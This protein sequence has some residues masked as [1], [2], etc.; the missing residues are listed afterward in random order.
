MEE[1]KMQE[2]PVKN[3]AGEVAFNLIRINMPVRPQQ[4]PVEEEEEKKEGAIGPKAAAEAEGAEGAEDMK[5]K[6][7]LNLGARLP[8]ADRKFA[9]KE[10]FRFGIDVDEAPANVRVKNEAGKPDRHV[11]RWL[12]LAA[13]F[14]IPDPDNPEVTYPSVEHYLAGMK[15]KLASSKPDL[16]E[17][18]LSTKGAIHQQFL[19]DR[20]AQ[21]VRKDSTADFALLAEEAKEV[22]KKSTESELHNFQTTLDSDKWNL[23]KDEELMYALRYRWEN[24]R[25]FHEIVV[26]ARDVGKYLLYRTRIAAAVS[27]LGGERDAKTGRIEGENKVGRYIMELAKYVF[28]EQPVAPVASVAPVAK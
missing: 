26:A 23:M 5:G 7:E 20:L 17:K 19:R 8:S 28:Q 18:L 25:R 27:E 13:P 15:L 10:L 2:E 3:R 11:A 16:A 22:R 21:K 6:I 1:Y 14:P 9:V 4:A 24:D 12:S